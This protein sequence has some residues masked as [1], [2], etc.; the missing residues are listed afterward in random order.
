MVIVTVINILFVQ[1]SIMLDLH[2]M[3]L[4][5]FFGCLADTKTRKW[6]FSLEDYKRLSE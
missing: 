6:S 1:S 3:A 5:T 2:F 4:I